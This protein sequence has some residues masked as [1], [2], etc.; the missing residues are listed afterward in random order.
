MASLCSRACFA[1]VSEGLLWSRL[2]LSRW[3]T[4]VETSVG[5]TSTLRCVL[6]LRIWRWLRQPVGEGDRCERMMKM[7]CNERECGRA[8]GDSQRVSGVR[9]R[10]V[11]MTEGAPRVVVRRT[12]VIDAVPC[13]CSP[14][15][16]SVVVLGN[17]S[18][19]DAELRRLLDEPLT[20]PLGSMLSLG[21]FVL[22]ERAEHEDDEITLVQ[23][24]SKRLVLADPLRVESLSST[25]LLS[26]E[27]DAERLAGTQPTSARE[28]KLE[29]AHSQPEQRVESQKT[30]VRRAPSR[31]AARA[32]L[33]P[34]DAPPRS[35]AL[36]AGI[37]DGWE[38]LPSKTARVPT[39]RPWA[40]AA[41]RYQVWAT[42]AVVAVFA[43]VLAF[44]LTLHVVP[45]AKPRY[46]SGQPASLPRPS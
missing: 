20:R 24:R 30:Q 26:T 34:P 6:C 33:S 43:L 39:V 17:V 25:E 18:L 9:E 2:W 23:D 13:A 27:A 31:R 4:D 12:V 3:Q 41:D 28:R 45:K 36:F 21:C 15:R 11:D 8:V 29:K 14:E 37:I 35:S 38:R 32:T 7:P 10:H 16:Q 40:Q 42:A 44:A 1:A 46:Q 22:S 5:A 19:H